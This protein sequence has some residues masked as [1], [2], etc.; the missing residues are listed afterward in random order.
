MQNI[1]VVLL[2]KAFFALDL[3]SLIVVIIYILIAAVISILFI[4]FSLGKEL[5]LFNNCRRPIMIFKSSREDMEI[6]TKL[7]R[8]TKLFNIPEEPTDKHQ[9][10][11]RIKEHSL[12]IIGYSDGMENFSNI[13]DGA[14][15]AG[16]P[17]IVYSKTEI[18]P[19]I[20]DLLRTY[21][22]FSICQFPLRLLNDVFTILS[23]FPA[24]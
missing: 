18:P 23:T 16:I 5:R 3:Y 17:V 7:L 12:I 8:D 9:N 20:K 6:E 10:I 2:N 19:N 4:N 21:S 11:D 24:K 13:Y 1:I 15:R 22:W 14:K